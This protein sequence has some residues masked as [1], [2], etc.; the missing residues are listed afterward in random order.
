MMGIQREPLNRHG[1]PSFATRGEGPR[2]LHLFLWTLCLALALAACSKSAAKP[3]EAGSALEQT[4]LR[5]QGAVGAV[6]FP[7]LAEDL[8][9]LA[10]LKLNFVGNTISGPQ[11]IQTVV[12]GDTDYGVA[13]N[14]A[15]IKLI[16]AKA[17]IRAVIAAYGV[18][19]TTWT[20]FYVPE[21]SPIHGPRDLIGK[22]V[23]MNTLGAHHEF[24]LREYL[25]RNGLSPAEAKGVTLVVIPPVS[26]EQTLRAH[27]V[28]VA[29]LGGILRDKALER[30][31]LR[32]LFSDYQLYGSFNAGTYVF[33]EKFIKDNPKTVARFVEGT[34][35]AIEWARTTPKDQVVARF[36]DI[37]Q[38][39]GRGEDPAAVRYWKTTGID[40]PGGVIR[41]RDFAVWI[42]WLV[43]AGELK[44]GEVT[45]SPLFTNEF[46]P[47]VTNAVA[48]KAAP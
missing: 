2:T 10:P 27:Q 46:N 5:H 34:A 3:G 23:S 25:E 36:V 33:K 19:D 15:V 48:S 32:L 26:A 17:P 31:G 45:P 30:G 38:K 41:D 18:D 1:E 13:F 14:G 7:E 11:D 16:V 37:I 22:K 47:F 44:P 12:T 28:D 20:G 40:S 42:D 24:I 29:T 4:E 43:R 21:D 35:R 8:G 6:S 39:R 9:Y